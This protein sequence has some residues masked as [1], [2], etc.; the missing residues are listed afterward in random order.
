MLGSNGEAPL[1]DELESDAVIETVRASVPKDRL[2][3]AGTGRESTRATIDASG[4]TAALGADAAL[5]RT[6]SHFKPT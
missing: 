6:P 5:V 4:R 1:V 2:V 3:I